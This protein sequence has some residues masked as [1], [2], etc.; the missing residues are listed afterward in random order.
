MEDRRKFPRI[1]ETWELEYRTVTAEEFK[2]NS[3]SSLTVNVSSGGICFNA[4]KEIAK[5]TML[6]IKLKSPIFPSS[7]IAL[8]ET[9]WCRKAETKDKYEV[10]VSLWWS[11]W[12]DND[13]QQVL[14]DYISQKTH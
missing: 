5:G 8:A 6:A 13:V 1:E 11:G 7:I 10:G 14:E 2:N 9:V 3:I 12:K 4:E